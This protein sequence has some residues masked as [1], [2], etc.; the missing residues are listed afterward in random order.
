MPSLSNI[1]GIHQRRGAQLAYNTGKLHIWYSIPL[2]I[3]RKTYIN[4]ASQGGALRNDRAVAE[5]Y[6]D[7]LCEAV[8]FKET[9]SPQIWMGMPIILNVQCKVPPGWPITKTKHTQKP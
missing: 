5:S 9:H 7:E 2:G 4:D 8:Q 1:T 3:L 6:C